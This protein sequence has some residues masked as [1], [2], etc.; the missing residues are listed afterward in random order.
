MGSI[1]SAVGTAARF[2]GAGG[3]INR[4]PWPITVCDDMSKEDNIDRVWDI[5]ERSVCACLRHSPAA[6]CA[7][8]LEARPDRDA[9]LSLAFGTFPAVRPNP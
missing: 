8:P 5:M 9:G 7:R 6:G 2:T 3:A 1:R 4:E